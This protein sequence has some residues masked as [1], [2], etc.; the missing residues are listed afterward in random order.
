MGEV[1]GGERGNFEFGFFHLEDDGFRPWPNLQPVLASLLYTQ[2]C[3]YN[4]DT[5]IRL[6]KK[7]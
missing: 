6:Q 1:R 4:N 2:T 3:T 5:I 7:N